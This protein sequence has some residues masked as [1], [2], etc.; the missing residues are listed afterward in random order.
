M[1]IMIVDHVVNHRPNVIFSELY[2][3]VLHVGV[4]GGVVIASQEAVAPADCKFPATFR[5]GS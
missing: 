1:M 3:I 5:H 4:A 2:T